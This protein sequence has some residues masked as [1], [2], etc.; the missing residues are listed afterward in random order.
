MFGQANTGTE[1][2]DETE[3]VLTGNLSQNEEEKVKEH[4]GKRTYKV[5]RSDFEDLS[6]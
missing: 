6:T 3:A 4:S 1:K 5:F 2:G